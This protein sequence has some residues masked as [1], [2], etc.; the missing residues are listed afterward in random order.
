MRKPNLNKSLTVAALFLWSTVGMAAEMIP[1]KGVYVKKVLVDGGDPTLNFG[2]CMANISLPA[3]FIWPA[4]CAPT[5][6]I[7][8]D[9]WVTFSC[10]GDFATNQVQA[11]RLLDQAQ[12]A[13]AGN[14]KVDVYFTNDKHNGYCFAYRIDVIK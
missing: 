9:P 11:Y 2:G 3:K 14:K 10:T 1:V 4:E 13:L 7:A 12:L 5:P 8:K 6:A